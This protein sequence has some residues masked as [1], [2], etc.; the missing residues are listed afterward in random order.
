MTVAKSD[1]KPTEPS[2]DATGAK[3]HTGLYVIGAVVV[4]A[5]IAGVFF[6]RDGA[7]AIRTHR[8]KTRRSPC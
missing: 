4:A 7:P 2:T 1:K 5:V 6:M 8:S 3:S